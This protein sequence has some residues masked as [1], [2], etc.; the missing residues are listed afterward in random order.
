MY[1]NNNNNNDDN[2]NNKN[3]SVS[4]VRCVAAI[5]FRVKNVR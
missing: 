3:F 1:Q 4:G 2:K 5:S